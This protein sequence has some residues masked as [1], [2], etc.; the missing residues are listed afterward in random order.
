MPAMGARC[1]IFS[2][3]Q[4]DLNNIVATRTR[5]LQSVRL[6]LNKELNFA[7]IIA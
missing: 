6:E 4:G 5:Y 7:I 1:D 3:N 2:L